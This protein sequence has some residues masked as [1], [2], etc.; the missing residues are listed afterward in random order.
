MIFVLTP[1][2]RLHTAVMAVESDDGSNLIWSLQD[3]RAAG[4][5]PTS[6]ARYVRLLPLAAVP[7]IA[8]HTQSAQGGAWVAK[9]TVSPKIVRFTYLFL[10]AEVMFAAW[11]VDLH[12]QWMLCLAYLLL[13]R[14]PHVSRADKRRPG[15]FF[16]QGEGPETM[17]TWL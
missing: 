2:R 15:V 13:S 1:S 5:H 8:I 17:P 4:L 12:W 11:S 9:F 14:T 16:F 7:D 6:I 3:L 10:A